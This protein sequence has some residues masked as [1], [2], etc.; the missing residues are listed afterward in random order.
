[1]NAD[2]EIIQTAE[3][4]RT[5]DRPHFTP[6]VGI[7]E[8]EDGLTLVADLPG[9]PKGNLSVS[10][11]EGALKIEGSMNLDLPDGIK[12]VYREFEEGVFQ[13]SFNL[14][15]ELDP[16][17]IQ[18]NFEDGVLRLHIGKSERAITRQIEVK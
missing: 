17:K 13:R 18:A 7:Y 16:A 8:T 11:D 5:E 1:M 9:V 15:D 12:T 4:E 10:V 3:V 6:N 2:K 14:P